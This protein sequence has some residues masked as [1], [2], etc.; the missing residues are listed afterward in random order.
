M[1]SIFSNKIV[2]V[3]IVAVMVIVTAISLMLIF[4]DR[5]ESNDK[6]LVYTSFYP[7]Y[8]FTKKVGGNRVEVVNIVGDGEEAHGFDISAQLLT[9]LYDADLI[10][11]NGQNM[12][13]SWTD[14]LDTTLQNKILD[15]STNTSLIDRPSGSHHSGKDPHIWL[16]LTNA[17]I[18]M[19]N[20]KDK[21]VELDADNADYY[22][23]NYGK[24][25][26][27]FDGLHS[28][29]ETL[30]SPF[31][32]QTFIVSHGAFGYIAND[33]N[34]VQVS[35]SGLE[36]E[37]EPS[38][39]DMQMI[40]DTI[41]EKNVKTVFYHD[42]ISDNMVQVLKSQTSVEHIKTLSTI[43]G[44]TTNQKKSDDDYLSLMAHNL[45]QLVA[46]FEAN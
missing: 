31:A 9:Q 15:T 46:S 18:Q 41:N 33:F 12:E 44:L 36:S 29:Y 17:K 8:D 14:K 40:I 5:D 21:L 3:I 1:K 26:L 7:L 13:Q 43:E 32:N 20:I 42:F 6:L 27:L 11:I 22:N 34:L 37:E 4:K 24:Y 2:V 23:D 25:A 19:K 45:Y 35:I 30:L 28:Q 39:Q 38:A 16:S 10:V